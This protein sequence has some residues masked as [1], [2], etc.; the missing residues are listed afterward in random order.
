MRSG[1][2]GTEVSVRITTLAGILGCEIALFMCP[3]LSL[4]RSEE[5]FMI[6]VSKLNIYFNSS[7]S[8][9]AISID[10]TKYEVKTYVKRSMPVGK[11]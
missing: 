9:E 3:S 10:L 1:L 2:R 11:V 7:S 4:L 6:Y 5:K 8:T